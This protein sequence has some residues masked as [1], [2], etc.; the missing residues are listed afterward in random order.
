M[1]NSTNMQACTS[2]KWKTNVSHKCELLACCTSGNKS[3][4]YRQHMNWD[5]LPQVYNLNKNSTMRTYWNFKNASNPYITCLQ[6]GISSYLYLPA[7]AGRTLFPWGGFSPS[8]ILNN[9][10]FLFWSIYQ[11]RSK[12]NFLFNVSNQHPS[13]QKGH[14]YWVVDMCA[15]TLN[16]FYAIIFC[17]CLVIGTTAGRMGKVLTSVQSYGWPI[18]IFY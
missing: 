1:R 17:F 14:Y 10:G 7:D 18:R 13:R 6:L 11:Q 3:I 5:L 15:Y 9:F 16:F 2:L 12:A 8:A 4:F